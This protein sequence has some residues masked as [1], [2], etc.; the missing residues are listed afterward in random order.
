MTNEEL[1]NEF[2]ILYN[3]IASNQAPS[4]DLYEKS[5]FLTQAQDDI[6]KHYFNPILN[7]SQAGFDGNEKRQID[8]SM[9]LRTETVNSFLD[10]KLDNKYNT[11]RVKLDNGDGKI[12]LIINEFVDV[13][14]RN[15]PQRLSVLDISYADY[16]RLRSKPFKRPAKYQAWRLLDSIDSSKEAELIVGP[17]DTIESYT[18][19]YIKKPK[20]IILDDLSEL[21]V[22]IDGLTSKQECELDPIIHPELLQRAVELA[23]AVYAEGLTTQLALGQA[24]QTNIGAVQTS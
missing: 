12:M 15:Q 22:S 18:I 16:Q 10:P 13:L 21:G 5:V 9:I 2:D 23:K 20:P 6:I 24:S 11:K 3:S 1:N 19:R 17:D 14:R 8:F 7:K 4:L